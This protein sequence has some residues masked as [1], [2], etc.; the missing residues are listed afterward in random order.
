MIAQ[1]A[2]RSGEVGIFRLD[3]HSDVF[4]DGVVQNGH[5]VSRAGGGGPALIVAIEDRLDD[6]LVVPARGLADGRVA[7]AE[8][9]K[10][11]EFIF[12]TEVKVAR[13]A[14]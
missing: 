1:K 12:V 14:R 8:A 10:A 2:V 4:G 11:A 7:I 5:V 6:V 13:F 3:L 9:R